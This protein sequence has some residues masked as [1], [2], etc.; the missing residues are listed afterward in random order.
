MNPVDTGK[1]IASLRKKAGYT[2]AAL[3]E[4][5]DVSDKAVSKWERG[6]AC[7]DIS[8]L[9]KLSVLL[10][11]D[12]EGLLSGDVLPRDRKWCGVLVLDDMALAEVYSK[13]LVYFLLSN[14]LLV[15]IR[16]ILI[17]G[18]SVE[19]LL[20]DGSQFGLRLT[21][22]KDS[23]GQALEHN[24][25]FCESNTMLI[26]GNVFVYGAHLTRRYQGMMAQQDGSIRLYS[27][28]GDPLPIAFITDECWKTA[29]KKAGT[30]TNP[31]DL[32]LTADP[33]Q[34]KLVRGIT[35]LPMTNQE[36]IFT[37]TTFVRTIEK[38]NKER[39]ADLTELALNRG[40]IHR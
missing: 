28:R 14:F 1:A 38:D 11:T 5:L 39:I 8:F 16:K 4:A 33:K 35:C 26:L 2:Q 22:S 34:K 30:W 12:I 20:G 24:I 7:P 9:P 27:Y 6:L 32:L 25:E 23:I 15:G 3:S 36:E 40:M 18:G 21:Y 29:M 37:A 17:I 10:D 31:E 19:E 13:P